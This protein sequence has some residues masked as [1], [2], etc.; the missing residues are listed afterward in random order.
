[1][2]DQGMMEG[3]ESAIAGSHPRLIRE[4]KTIEAMIRMHCRF[5]HHTPDGLCPDCH[6]LLAYARE[7]LGRCPYQELKTTC[8]RCLIHCYKPVMRDKI[9]TAMRY[10]GPRM[11]YRHPL[12]ALYHLIDGLRKEPSKPERSRFSRVHRVP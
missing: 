5:R 1:L 7:R 2:K 9:R 10:A 6:E 11:M 4:N 8:A 12:L 3:K